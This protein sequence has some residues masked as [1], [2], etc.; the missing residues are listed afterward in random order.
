MMGQDVF[1]GGGYF[2]GLLMEKSKSDTP[3]SILARVQFEKRASI[4]S[5]TGTV[6]TVPGDVD[7][8]ERLL[9][10]IYSRLQE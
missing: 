9:N 3:F 2:K 10:N 7:V 1:N 6:R 5:P 4:F 8:V